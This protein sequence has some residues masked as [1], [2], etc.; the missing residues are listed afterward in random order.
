[1]HSG[2]GRGD[3]PPCCTRDMISVSS[4]AAIDDASACGWRRVCCG[5]LGA[6]WV[7]RATMGW[8]LAVSKAFPSC[9]R[10]VWTE[11]YL[12]HACCSAQQLRVHDGKRPGMQGSQWGAS[13]RTERRSV[14]RC[15]PASTTC[16][17]RTRSSTRPSAA[18]SPSGART[19]PTS[20]R[21]LRLFTQRL[22]TQRLFTQRLFT[23]RRRGGA[24]A[25][26]H[27]HMHSGGGGGSTAQHTAH[28]Q[29]TAHS[30]AQQQ[31]A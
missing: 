21:C 7:R 24:C 31:R 16:R 18:A 27:A 4:T 10:S 22:F 2:V 3:V 30:T 8:A 5:G 29:H 19:S 20:W 13:R 1:M 26:T 14:G 17:T 11:M 23:P 6:A 28:T 15:S 12:C 25:R 9:V